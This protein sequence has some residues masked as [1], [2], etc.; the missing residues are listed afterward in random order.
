MRRRKFPGKLDT[1]G[2]LAHWKRLG[3]RTGG[4]MG[5]H[6]GTQLGLMRSAVCHS[7]QPSRSGPILDFWRHLL[8]CVGFRTCYLEPKWLRTL[9]LCFNLFVQPFCSFGESTAR[10]KTNT[11]DANRSLYIPSQGQRPRPAAT[12]LDLDAYDADLPV[13]FQF[14]RGAANLL[15]IAPA[16][17]KSQGREEQR[18]S[19]QRLGLPRPVILRRPC[20][21]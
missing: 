12:S 8:G 7:Y 2:C 15:C 4:R 19:M 5:G 3:G 17:R 21:L 10:T 16:P 20:H 13:S 6:T 18:A 9:F 14:S 1:S 11:S